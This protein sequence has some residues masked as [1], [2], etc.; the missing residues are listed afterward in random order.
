[1]H[2]YNLHVLNK[3]N[4]NDTDNF[5]HWTPVYAF[6]VSN[7]LQFDSFQSVLHIKIYMQMHAYTDNPIVLISFGWTLFISMSHNLLFCTFFFLAQQK[8]NRYYI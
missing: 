5:M 2:I 3:E 7:N 1:M 4:P 6:L 8:Q